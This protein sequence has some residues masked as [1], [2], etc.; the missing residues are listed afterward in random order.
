MSFKLPSLPSWLHGSILSK[1]G[2]N[3]ASISLPLLFSDLATSAESTEMK[4][5]PSWLF[6]SLSISSDSPYF[7]NF[8]P[9]FA[10]WTLSLSKIPPVVPDFAK[11]CTLQNSIEGSLQNPVR[12]PT[13]NRPKQ[14]D[15]PLGL[16]Y[17]TSLHSF[18]ADLQLISQAS[19]D[20]A[21][22]PRENFVCFSFPPC[23]D[24]LSSLNIITGLC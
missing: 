3:H 10:P 17:L 20:W 11:S 9:F 7:A 6:T 15:V 24:I 18:F 1:A 8:I 4:G 22:R 23:S 16:L 19:K 12:A 13:R 21:G 2:K 14:L 5:S